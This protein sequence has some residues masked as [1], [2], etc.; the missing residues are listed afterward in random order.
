MISSM[1]CCI[2]TCAM[3]PAAP[4][5]SAGLVR[6][7]P[8]PANWTNPLIWPLFPF[9]TPVL[10]FVFELFLSP[11]LLTSCVERTSI[12]ESTSGND[13]RRRTAA[14]TPVYIDGEPELRQLQCDR[15]SHAPGSLRLRR[16][17]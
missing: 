8:G 17:N 12:A 5:S 6:S 15:S 16:L 1:V 2:A 3:I 13:P 4:A 7:D 9:S 10:R 14:R 11:Y